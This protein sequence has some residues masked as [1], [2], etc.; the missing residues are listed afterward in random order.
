MKRLSS[1]E[2]KRHNG[3]DRSGTR[4]PGIEIVCAVAAAPYP[5]L[6]GETTQTTPSSEFNGSQTLGAGSLSTS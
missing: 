3:L 1:Q 2:V 6:E 4:V 5:S